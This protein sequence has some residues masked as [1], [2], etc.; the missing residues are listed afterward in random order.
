MADKDDAKYSARWWLEQ[1]ASQEKVLDD[2]WRRG[3]DKIVKK[4]LDKR[5]GEGQATFNYNVFWANTGILKA[6][7][8][9]KPP[10]PL[11]SRTWEDPNDEAGRVG[12]RIIQRIL[13]HD[14]QKDHS[15]ID[16]SFRLAI[17]DT[18][19]PGLGQV[20]HRYEAKLEKVVV[21]AVVDPIT[22]TEL[23]AAVEAEK[24]VEENVISEYLYWRDFV[25]GACRI[26]DE[27]PWV[28]RRTYM[29]S[30]AFTKR[31][32]KAKFELLKGKFSSP[33]K[34]DDKQQ[35]DFK[36][37]RITVWEL[38]CKESRKVYFVTPGFD[39]MLDEKPDPLNLDKFYPCPKPLLATHTTDS[40]IPRPDYVMVQD[41]YEELNELNTRIF[42]IEKSLRVLG[43][44]D[45]TNKE[46]SR[47][48]TEARE[49]Q[50]IPVANWGNLSEKN[51]LKGVIDWFPLDTIADVLEKL[52]QQKQDRL[53]EIYELTG[54]SDIMRGVS[55]ARETA[56]AQ[57]LKAQYSSVRLQYRQSEVARFAEDSL[58][59]RSQIISNHFQPETIL[60]K[61]QIQLTEDGPTAQAAIQ[62]IKDK[63]IAQYRIRVA[64]ESLAL[65]DYNAERET[66]V[67]YL[68]AVGQFVSQMMPLVESKPEAAPYMI[69]MIQWVSSGFRGAQQMEGV[70][71]QAFAAMTKAAMTPPPPPPPDPKIIVEQM[72]GEL[73]K[74]IAMSDAM[75]EKMREDAETEREAMR[76][77]NEERIAAEKNASAEQIASL[78]ASTDV[79]LEQMK[80][81][82]EKD[83]AEMTKRMELMTQVLSIAMQGK[84]A[85]ELEELRGEI[86]LSLGDQATQGKVLQDLVKEVARPKVRRVTKRTPEGKIEEVTEEGAS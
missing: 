70:L 14:L 38:W 66:R 83:L 58:R 41:Q 50:M 75:L 79:M 53:Q 51:G 23:A 52:R 6:A 69:K 29:T 15:D 80:Q 17:D 42:L 65:P 56:A 25:W 3:A 68:T 64:E 44:Y 28:G 54:I 55:E 1:I 37:D 35:K 45:Q 76:I 46:L 19:I 27:C 40:L 72:R 81:G 71:N 61:S 7:L 63:G 26:W 84:Q 39:N 20:W 13:E 31:F 9:A 85:Q 34:D 12:A 22:G 11:V 5:R 59:I 36:K 16:E 60:K 33:S 57:K 49:N 86:D 73:E 4:Y 67:E 77:A 10:R 62:L 21:P 30:Q 18:L 32:G 43:V 24:V 8:Y 78:K 48:L 82:F 2:E 47:L 74:K